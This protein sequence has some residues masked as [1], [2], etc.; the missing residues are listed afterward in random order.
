MSDAADFAGDEAP[1]HV[2][3]VLV[4]DISLACR[5]ALEAGVGAEPVQ[6]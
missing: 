1:P 6:A 4:D 5:H 2:E 3:Q